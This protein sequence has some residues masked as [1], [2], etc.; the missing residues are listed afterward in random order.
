MKADKKVEVEIRNLLEKMAEAYRKKDIGSVMSCYAIGSDVVSYGTGKDE[1][2]IGQEQMRK[3]YERD[4][5][6]SESVALAFDWLAISTNRTRN[7]AWFASDITVRAKVSGKEVTLPC[8]LTGVME[9]RSGSWLIVQGHFSLPAAEQ[10]EGQSFP[11][12][13]QTGN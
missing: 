12:Q 9:K 3:A 10:P 4:F 11:G 5:A 7:V 1:K 8:R 13:E 2:Y 6:Q